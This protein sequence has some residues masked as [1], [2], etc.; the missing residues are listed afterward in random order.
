MVQRIISLIVILI[1][2]LG[3]GVYAFRALAPAP[4]D[5][6]QGPQYATTPVRRGDIT[7][8]VTATGGLNPTQGG[9]IYV[10]WPR[11]PI[12]GPFPSNFTVTEVYVQEGDV[13]T[14]GQPLVELSAPSMEGQLRDLE[15]QLQQER[16]NLA[17]RL[18]V[19]P[20]QLSGINPAAGITLH[21]PI[22]GRVTNLEVAEGGEVE[23]GAAVARVVNDS[24]WALTAT[25]TPAEFN[26]IQSGQR[27]AVRFPDFAG[28]LDARVASINPNAVP[29]SS[30]EL[31]DCR[32]NED[33]NTS[34]RT[35]FVYRVKLHG[36]NPGLIVPGMVAEVGLLPAGMPET[37]T[38][39]Q[40]AD[41]IT[42]FRY[43]SH[44]EGYG[45]EER[46]L[47][48]AKGIV[49]KL[50]VQEME[51]VEAGAP[52]VSLAGEETT[53]SIETALQK[54]RD[55]EMQVQSMREF[56]NDLTVKAPMN[57][58]VA[59][60]RAQVGQSIEIGEHLGS[61]YNPEEMEMWVQVD[62]VDVLRVQ[63]DSP[64]EV[65]VE[66][67]GDEVLSGRVV[68]ISTSGRGEGGITFFQVRIQVEGNERLRPGMQAEAYIRSGEAK[69]VLLVPLEAVFQEDRQYK[70]EV[71]G[72]DGIPRVVPIE[73][74]LMSDFEAEVKS[75]LEEG[76]LVI[77]GSSADILPG[78]SQPPSLFPG[79]SGPGSS[80]VPSD[81]AEVPAMPV[82]MPDR[83][84]ETPE[85]GF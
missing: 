4:D 17:N 82:P 78:R 58:I 15:A 8:G 30:S 9:S 55:L 40:W 53:R 80:P 67:L 83:A 10:P 66:A 19:S 11:G 22:S 52:L 76:Q 23:Q 79:T 39:E 46:V 61:I 2:I 64:V 21:A 69:D 49:T 41:R 65:R 85:A 59:E 26:L 14:M 47:S 72:D 35:Q 31:L 60:L 63:Q 75:G 36:E 54:I 84:I 28:V 62:D 57:G 29:M 48:T 81:G 5:S 37:A 16:E 20:D 24:E 68:H 33:P 7:V 27:V 73:V 1:I 50:H 6:A 38:A 12:Y 43:C 18:G 70:V 42:W 51:I 45:S 3:G 74:G 34:P 25:L 71:L 56:M 13:V 77:T 32:E 44:V